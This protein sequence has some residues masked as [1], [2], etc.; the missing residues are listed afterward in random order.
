MLQFRA[1]VVLTQDRRTDK[2]THTHTHT[3]ETV[4]NFKALYIACSSLNKLTS[5]ESTVAT[6]SNKQ[7]S[8]DCLLS[9]SILPGKDMDISQFNRTSVEVSHNT[10][11]VFVIFTT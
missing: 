3:N 6:L 7:L 11:F 2:H 4:S 5:L 1:C 8:T 10:L 9:V